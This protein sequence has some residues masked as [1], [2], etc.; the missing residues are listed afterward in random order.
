MFVLLVRWR[1]STVFRSSKSWQ[2]GTAGLFFGL[3]LAWPSARAESPAPSLPTQLV[4]LGRQA[5]AQGAVPTAQTFYRKA[6]Q[7]DPTNKAAARGLE[8]SK[9]ADGAI[10][11]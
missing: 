11:R 4:E 5:L 8:E 6:L 1:A 3:A 10:V 9:R 7:L 2:S